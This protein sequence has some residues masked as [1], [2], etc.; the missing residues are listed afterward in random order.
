MWRGGLGRA[1]PV[2]GPF[3][4]RCLT[5]PAVLRFHTPLIKPDVQISCIRLSDK[6]SRV[7][8]QTVANKPFK[9]YERLCAEVVEVGQRRGAPR[10]GTNGS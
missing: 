7:R 5:S 6:A 9:V 3:G 2:A 1:Y 8:P 10:V 4:C